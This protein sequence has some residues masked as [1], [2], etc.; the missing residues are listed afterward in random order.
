MEGQASRGK[1]KEGGNST[2]A[3]V[4]QVRTEHLD[5]N[6]H[7]DFTTKTLKGYVDLTLHALVPDLSEVMLDTRDL[8][9]SAISD[10][11]SSR[12]LEFKLSE[13]HE[14]F[15]S[16]LHITL[17]HPPQ[18]G[19]SFRIRIHYETS[20]N[21]SGIQWLPPSQTE[22][23]VHPYMFTQFQAIHAR[24]GLPCQDT[25]YV[26]APYSAEI[27]VAK[28]LVALMS[29]ILV[30]V[31]SNESAQT[32]T[33]VFEQKVP[34]PS[35]LFAFVAGALV[36][37]DVGPRTRVWTEQEKIEAGAWEFAETE[38]Y[39]KTAEEILT[40]YEWGRYDVL[41]LPGSFPYG[42]MEN[43]C[44][45]FVTPTLIAGDR[46]LT[47]VV[48]HEIAHS[49]MGNLVGCSG[50]EHFWL[51][52]GFTVFIE[53]K[54]I[55]RVYGA[56]E[57]GLAAIS[58][59]HHLREDVERFMAMAA[60]HPSFTTLVQ[61]LE[62]IDPDD[63]FS[64]VPYERGFQFLYFLELTVGGPE[65]FEP[66]LQTYV[67][68]YANKAVNSF[69]FKAY[70][71]EYFGALSGFDQSKLEAIDWDA[72][73]FQKGMPPVDMVDKFEASLR[74]KALELASQW[75]QW[76]A[77]AQAQPP[78]ALHA[79]ATEFTKWSTSQKLAFL[80]NLSAQETAIPVAKLEQMDRL[81]ELT[82]SRNAEIR[83]RWYMLAI[84]SSYERVFPFAAQFLTEQGRMKYI[85]PLYRALYANEKG[86]ALALETFQRHK[87]NYHSIAQ[88][89]VGKDLSA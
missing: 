50:W 25:P 9:I 29:A 67:K 30:G 69:E 70:F 11:T 47:S 61:P 41:M 81:Y 71:L 38:K 33:Y 57:A 84:R 14:A 63:A 32:T 74:V 12:Q 75:L 52:E 13:P 15:G 26:K 49:W 76:D 42:G 19:T 34:I 88:K 68:K 62:G 22:G 77:H 85:R 80:E 46:S 24:S 55:G 5:L 56:G 21:S 79:S 3:N 4:S 16:A 39:L 72:W 73:Y 37:R 89:M 20:P 28:P 6:L 40:P 23:K 65:V 64:S 78:A 58:G 36:S 17:S 87:E 10:L 2:F 44:L 8:K 1:E 45:T 7:V 83:F 18:Q 43:P 60:P 53:R 35:Y 82:S 48:A 31:D 54:I 66:F 86:R 27:T 51:N 59:N